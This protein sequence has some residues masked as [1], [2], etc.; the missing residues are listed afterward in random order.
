MLHGLPLAA[1][2]ALGP[3]AGCT[4]AAPAA[5]AEVERSAT[6]AERKADQAESEAVRS[7]NPGAAR[8]AELARQEAVEARRSAAAAAC[9]PPPPEPARKAPRG[10]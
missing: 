3:G 4:P 9:R 5:L 7:G 10:Y 2:L 1:L 6:A 8:R